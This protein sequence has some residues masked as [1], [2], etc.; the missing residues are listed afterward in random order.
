MFIIPLKI[1]KPLKKQDEGRKKTGNKYGF[2]GDPNS[3]NKD[4]QIIVINLIKKIDSKNRDFRQRNRIYKYNL[5]ESLEL[6][7]YNN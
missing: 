6:K 4:L 1:T 2:I 5:I 7:K 3:M